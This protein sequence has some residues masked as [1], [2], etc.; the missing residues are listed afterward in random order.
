MQYASLALG[1][2][3]IDLEAERRQQTQSDAVL[4]GQ[5]NSSQTSLGQSD[6]NQN[7]VSN[8]VTVNPSAPIAGS[9][10]EMF[11]QM[12]LL[13]QEV[14]ELR[15]RLEEQEYQLKQLREQ[16]L[17][18]YLDLD[19]RLKGSAGAVAEDGDTT[20]AGASE[21]V[22]LPAV[23]T[24]AG[25]EEAYRAAYGLVRS[26]QFDSAVT[27]FRQFL[28]DFPGGRYTPNAHYWLGELY[29]VLV[30]PDDESARREFTRLLEQYPNNSKVPDAL[31]K[32]GKIY[33]ER[34]NR[35]R[36]QA[37]LQRVVNEFAN[38][39]SSAVRLAQDF[40]SSNF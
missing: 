14:M 36:A 40:L 18:Q 22:T 7:N 21:T 2:E 11:Y 32:L 4:T 12:Q 10:G 29:L 26:Q 8:T 16:S 30:P 3:Y 27:A 17:E 28:V 24:L 15:G 19:Q 38:S 20:E 37:Y 1:Q 9:A 25:E 5:D 23:R 33:Y 34:G 35:D 6:P 13:Q 31:Y 39:G